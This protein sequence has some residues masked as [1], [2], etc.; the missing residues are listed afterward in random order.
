[1]VEEFSARETSIVAGIPC[2]YCRLKELS[3]A[4]KE[5]DPLHVQGLADALGDGPQQGLGFG[6]AARLFGEV[7]QY[8]IDGVGLAK[9]APVNPQGKRP[10]NAQTQKQN[11]D[12]EYHGGDEL[13]RA[14]GGMGKVEERKPRKAKT[15]TCSTHSVP[16]AKA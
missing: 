1:M 15:M 13:G 5:G 10:G 14:A 2:A 8:L 11:D 6:E 16:R 4:Q 12:D 3:L 7:H 9:E